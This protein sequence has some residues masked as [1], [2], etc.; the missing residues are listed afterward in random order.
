MNFLGSHLTAADT[1]WRTALTTIVFLCA[2]SMAVAGE[3]GQS[4]PYSG[5]FLTRSTFTGDWGGLRNDLSQNG[6]TFNAN[7]TQTDQGVVNGGKNSSWEYGGRSELTVKMDSGKM[8]L[9]QGGTLTVE[10]EGNWG[11]AV[12]RYTGALMLADT[13]QAF[14]VVGKDVFALPALNYTQFL[15]PNVGFVV[16]KLDTI[17]EGDFNEFAHGKGDTQF[18]NLAFNINPALVLTVPYST[19]G[20][21][22][23]VLPTKDPEAAFMTF[24]ALSSEGEAN[25]SGFS[26]LSADMVTFVSEAR[27]RTDFLGLT[28]HQ[29]V[30]VTYSNKEFTSLDQRLGAFLEN[31][32]LLKKKGSWSFFYNFDQYLYEPKKGSGIGIFGRF[33]TSEGNPNPVHYFVSLGVGGKGVADRPNDQF[34]IGWYYLNVGNPTLVTLTGVRELLRDEQGFEAYYSFAITP[35]ALLTPDVQVVFPAQEAT[36][37][38]KKLGTETITGFR[39]RVVL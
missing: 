8:G 34:G 32:E 38:G 24:S 36:R 25:Q 17:A 30:G 22:L 37:D 13:N 33:G 31:N 29:L 10:L 35:W 15:S 18:M 20:A 16:G 7:V 27:V 23:I 11:E 6:I 28:G 4:E 39:F 3:Q 14:P 2:V 9:W 5:D 21:G 19:L 12:N 26:T 1:A